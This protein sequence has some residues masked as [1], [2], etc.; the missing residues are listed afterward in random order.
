LLKRVGYTKFDNNPE[1][2]EMELDDQVE[3]PAMLPAGAEESAETY[4]FGLNDVIAASDYR[5]ADYQGNLDQVNAL[6]VTYLLGKDNNAIVTRNSDSKI[7]LQ[8]NIDE[9][10][11]IKDVVITR[12]NNGKVTLDG[13]KP[14]SEEVDADTKETYENLKSAILE[15]AVLD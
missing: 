14:A 1:D 7:S 12:N 4:E 5:S 3:D 2:P 8:F 9:H 11:E 10:P 15:E 6:G 13:I